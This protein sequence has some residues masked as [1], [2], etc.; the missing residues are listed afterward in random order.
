MPGMPSTEICDSIDNDCDGTTDEDFTT[1]GMPCTMGVG[2]C[3]MPGVF[4]CNP[5]GGTM[6]DALAGEPSPE[7]CDSIDNNCDGTTDEGFGLGMMC[8]AGVGACLSAGVLACDG[9]GGAACTAMAGMPSAE[10]C[11]GIDNN[12]DGTT[13]EG[14]G[15]GMM[16][17]AGVGACQAQGFVICNM[18][19]TPTCDATPGTPVAETC[20]GIDDDCDGTIDNGN[21][22]SGMVC[23]T[24]LPGICADG[25]TACNAQGMIECTVVTQPGTVTE[26]CADQLDNNC[27]GSVDEGCPVDSD[28]D[29]LLD[30]EEVA[31]GTDPNDA[32]SDD[33]GIL[34]GD[35]PEYATDT[36]GDGSI[37]ANDP[38]SDNDGLADGTEVGNDCSN[39]DT[40]P[41][42]GNCKPDGDMGT[43]KTN[44]LDADT[45]DGTVNDGVEDANHDGVVD[46]GETD[47]NVKE[48]DIP[49]MPDCTQDSDCGDKKSGR[50]CDIAGGNVCVDGCHL[51]GNGCPDAFTCNATGD[52][53][54]QCIPVEVPPTDIITGS[55][56]CNVSPGRTSNNATAIFLSAAL[57]L[58]LAIRRRRSQRS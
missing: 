38:D 56:F 14:F 58:A 7:V 12:C 46:T 51:M 30:D 43:T 55:G 28:G 3:E 17:T 1:L 25:S 9:N 22:G 54:G 2:A 44:P 27:D 41:A 20:N 32:D 39:P 42:A 34:D 16:C 29:G 6:C 19:G 8:T 37:N 4:V 36:D 47:P 53:I 26:V 45:D 21:P 18:A 48:D 40:D 10:V 23:S 35:E 13:D 50:V 33:D 52:E 57:G 31:I 15:L 49:T 24:G 5:S 11:D